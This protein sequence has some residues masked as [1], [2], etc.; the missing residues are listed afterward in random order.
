MGGLRLIDVKAGLANMNDDEE[1]WRDML[2]IYKKS[3]P[4]LLDSLGSRLVN[5]QYDEYIAEVH[6]LKSNA[7]LIGAYELSEDAKK[8][9]F[10]GKEKNFEY[11]D[12]NTE[13]LINDFNELL[14]EIDLLLVN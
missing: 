1:L 6:G 4:S 7:A 8:C 3:L 5:K 10:A 9:E 12:S 14:N 11:I 2:I 13:A